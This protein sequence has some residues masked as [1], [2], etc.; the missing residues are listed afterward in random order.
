[1]WKEEARDLLTHLLGARDEIDE[2]IRLLV[3]TIDTDDEEV[4]I[5]IDKKVMDS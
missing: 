1:M 5:I 4:F 2:D 3:S